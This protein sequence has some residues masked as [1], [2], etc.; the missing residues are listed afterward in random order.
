MRACNIIINIVEEKSLSTV[1]NPESSGKERTK[2]S[3]GIVLAIRELMQ[4]TEPD[5]LSRDLAAFIILALR[6]I[7]KT[8]ETSVVAWEKRGYW[9]KA[10]RF[11]M[12]WIW[13]QKLSSSLEQ[14][15]LNG[16]WM[17]VAILSTQIAQKFST[18]QIAAHHRLGTPWVGAWDA[19]QRN[20]QRGEKKFFSKP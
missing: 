19:F 11:R 14:A 16:D 9:V 3:K 8:I 10:D 12:E 18:I 17:N 6:E 15:L 2:L 20:I 5:D 4:Q 7:D 1:I 13:T